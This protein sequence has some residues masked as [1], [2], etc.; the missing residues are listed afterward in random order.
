MGTMTHDAHARVPRVGLLVALV[1][2]ASF[3]LSGALADG[4]LSAGWTPITVVILRLAIGA[5]C[6]T[7]F[8][9]RDLRGRWRTLLQDWRLVLAYSA[10]GM[11][12]AQLGYFSAVQHMPVGPALLIEY[13]APAA[14]VLWLWMRRG[15][16]P[17]AVTAVGAVIVA[18]GLVLVLG[19]L[20]GTRLSLPGVLWALLAMIG[21]AGFYLLAAH[22][23]RVPPTA[24]TAASLVLGS[25]MLLVIAATGLLPLGASAAPV[26]FAGGDVPWWVP[27]L[28]LGVISGGIAYSAGIAAVRRLGSRLASFV[29][30]LELVFA[31][32]FAWILLGQTPTIVQVI[33]GGLVLAGIIVLRLG[34]RP[35]VAT[36][37]TAEGLVAESVSRS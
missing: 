26:A 14:I 4:L 27:I 12:L 33:G 31:V 34:E 36:T 18:V 28:A 37:G 24:L 9:V 11:A 13:T 32:G 16:R 17:T 2:A 1:A 5:V 20:A 21:G 15:E 7:P 3:G 8:A 25:V 35:A 29:G 10:F 22:P 23:S 19:L 6:L 30:I